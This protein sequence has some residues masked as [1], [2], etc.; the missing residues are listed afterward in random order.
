MLGSLCLACMRHDYERMLFKDRYRAESIRIPERDYRTGTYFVTVCT[1]GRVPWFGSVWNGT[2]FHRAP[3]LIVIDEWQRT[4]D[5]RP[6]VTLDAWVVMP[7]HVHVIITINDRVETPRRGVSTVRKRLAAVMSGK[8]WR[9][10]WQSGCLGAIIN[11]WKS[12]CTKRI[13]DA[14]YPDFR[15]QTR[16]YETVI[17]DADHLE[18]VRAYIRNNPTRWSKGHHDHP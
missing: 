10:E 7:D 18:T 11:Q 5:I 17:R 8:H 1:N 16:Y 15:W 14:G 13:R 9:P 4:A 12:I 3:G 6:N 2:L